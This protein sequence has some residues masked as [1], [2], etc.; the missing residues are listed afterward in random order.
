MEIP[1]EVFWGFFVGG[2][3]SN[4]VKTKDGKELTQ[5]PQRAQRTQR[6]RKKSPERAE[7][8]VSGEQTIPS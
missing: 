4:E 3:R 7:G 5:R 6:K 2:R 8:A 1:G